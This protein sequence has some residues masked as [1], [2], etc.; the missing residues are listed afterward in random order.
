MRFDERQIEFILTIANEGG[1]SAASK[2]LYL[3]QPALSQRLANLEA[4]GRSLLDWCTGALDPFARLLGLD[5]VILTAFVLGWPAN[6]IVIPVMLMAYLSTGTLVEYG[7]LTAL[8]ELLS[9]RGWT[10]VTAVCVTLFALFHW[11]CSTTCLTIRRETGSWRWTALAA[12]IPTALG[13]ALCALTAGVGRLL[14]L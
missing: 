13:F 14:G 3:S 5:G 1:I 4:G 7:D 10:P 8:G 6:E 9:A 2:K 11:P 12:A